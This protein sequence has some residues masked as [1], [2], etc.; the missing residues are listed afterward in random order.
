MTTFAIRALPAPLPPLASL[1]PA[2]VRTIVV[3][4]PDAYPCRRCLTDA[5]PGE[6]V[7][8][9]SYDPFT[10][11]SPYR[12]PGPIFVHERD[13]AP[14]PGERIPNQ[15]TRRTL[16]LRSFDEQHLMVA[17]EVIDGSDLEEWA[18]RVLADARVAY[19]HVHNAG[20]GCF[21]ARLERRPRPVAP[22]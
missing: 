11:D 6:R 16:S 3:D 17:G 21:A 22:A 8:L 18:T 9:L 14:V 2:T 15:L 20:P 4:E 7:L 19:V 12:Q 1:S 5:L 10:G 13:C